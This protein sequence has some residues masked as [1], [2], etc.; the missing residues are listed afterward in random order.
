[1]SDAIANY[2][3]FSPAYTNEKDLLAEEH[4]TIALLSCLFLQKSK[5]SLFT[6]HNLRELPVISAMSLLVMSS[7]T[8]T[9]ERSRIAELS[10]SHY[11]LPY[12][13]DISP[14]AITKNI[15]P[16]FGERILKEFQPT[17]ENFD[18]SKSPK[19][20]LDEEIGD[21]N[22]YTS[23]QDLIISDPA[24]VRKFRESLENPDPELIKLRERI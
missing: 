13:I 11:S 21:I 18:V 23:G 9:R 8:T 20:I 19:G 5:S 4:L 17:D 14:L 7:D 6:G 24:E 10:F 2:S 3:S 15:S 12:T 1:M 16:V 22:H